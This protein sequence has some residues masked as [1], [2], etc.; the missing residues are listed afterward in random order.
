MTQ[1]KQPPAKLMLFVVIFLAFCAGF[2]A[3]AALDYLLQQ[4]S[5]LHGVSYLVGAFAS[6][7]LAIIF[8]L[9]LLKT[10]QNADEVAPHIHS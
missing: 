4:R 2:Q 8:G 7:L 6:C 9:G 3:S 1:I 5:G 10:H